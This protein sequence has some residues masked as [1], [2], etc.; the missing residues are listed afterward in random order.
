[1][2]HLAKVKNLGC[3]TKFGKKYAPLQP[4]IWNVPNSASVLKTT[5]F[6]TID[7]WNLRNP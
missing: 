3:K 5:L 2:Y 4:F 7:R 6:I 1:M